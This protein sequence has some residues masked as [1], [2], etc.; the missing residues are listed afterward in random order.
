MCVSPAQVMRERSEK[1]R[2]KW[3]AGGVPREDYLCRALA[4]CKQNDDM[5][6]TIGI[7]Q[8]CMCSM[9]IPPSYY[10]C[11]FWLSSKQLRSW[12]KYRYVYVIWCLLHTYLPI[13]VT[14]SSLYQYSELLAAPSLDL[15]ASQFAPALRTSYEELLTMGGNSSSVSTRVY[16][17]TMLVCVCVCAFIHP[18]SN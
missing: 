7:P 12:L 1:Q 6:Y 5:A 13:K 10:H 2:T 18:H 16:G 4:L 15:L 8:V 14:C 3:L 17:N 11:F 9:R